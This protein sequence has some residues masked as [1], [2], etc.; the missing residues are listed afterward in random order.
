MEL[1]SPAGSQ[2]AVIAAVQ[3]GADIVYI[4]A[5]LTSP[6]GLE[7]G[8][9][10][11]QIARALRYC[12]TR[13]CRTALALG[14]LVSDEGVESACRRAVFAAKNGVD[15]I[16]VEDIGLVRALRT[17]LP[18]M[19]LWGDVRM[20][21]STVG[22]ARAAAAIGLSRVALAPE[23]DLE[24]IRAVCAGAGIETTVCVQGHLCASRAGQCHMGAFSEARREAGEA[25]EEANGW[26]AELC[27]RRYDLGGRMDD[28]PLS[29]KE[30]C[31]LDHLGELADA[32]V[33]C[34]AIEGHGRSAEYVAFT[35][36][37][38]ARR[39]AARAAAT[40]EER[41]QLREYFC[42]GGLTDAYLRGD[43]EADVLGTAVEPTRRQTWER[44]RFFKQIRK[45]YINGELRRI[46][47]K[48]Y[49][50][51]Q[52]GEK[53]A[54]A[55]ED[56][57]GNR[58]EIRGF[59][60]VDLGRPGIPASRVRSILFRTAGT[61]YSCTEVLC[62]VDER[63]DYPDEEVKDAREKLL[64]RLSAMNREVKEPKV[65]ELPPVEAP[66]RP[67]PDEPKL[68]CQVS[69]REQLTEALACCDPD[70]LYVPLELAAEDAGALAPFR[71]RGIP[72]AAV[73]PRAVS[74]AE[75]DGVRAL[76]ERAAENGV[77]E[78]VGG[79]LGYLG[80]ARELG[81]GLR[82]DI[83]LNAA[84]A[85]TLEALRQAGMLSAAVSPLL[86]MAQIR[87][88]EKPLDLEMVVY[89]RVPVMV[90]EPCLLRRSA[91]R[92][93]CAR[94]VMMYGGDGEAFPVLKEYGCRSVIFDSGKIFL[95]DAAERY[96][97]AGLWGV[98]LLFSAEGPRECVEVT[99]RYKYREDY[100]PHGVTRGLYAKGIL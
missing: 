97:D 92:C 10:P 70:L 8:F 99:R 27:R 49:A 43:R 57:R 6:E 100:T 23:L 58:A 21:V 71:E 55:A 86:S 18:D 52:P 16:V 29:M 3:S 80:I 19:P 96:L 93:I 46:P 75:M 63:M 73:L 94:P 50:V 65:C 88:L 66:A 83:G 76:A 62:A 54:F 13:G 20:G 59:E 45:Q 69:R 81:L 39:I 47:V 32:G 64:A 14:G 36:G 82:G 38:Y 7:S 61:P 1:M 56:A 67:C 24:Q 15:A 79:S 26:C 17:V 44:R 31:L 53:A 90:T 60:P 87:A 48:F 22:G 28:Y 11:D 9:S 35:T 77:K 12:R 91:G 98:R 30:L 40:A 41:Q 51:I 85:R 37:L 4:G 2:E 5:G 74:Q 33:S 72:A 34:A 95:A 84:N 25:Q 89:G 42:P 78:L 68:I